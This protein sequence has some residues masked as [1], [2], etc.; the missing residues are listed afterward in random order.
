MGRFLRVPVPRAEPEP[1]L[2]L[3]FHLRSWP[4][5]PLAQ[6]AMLA[7]AA[8]GTSWT[9]DPSLPDGSPPVLTL[10]WPDGRTKV[11]RDPLG[12]FELVEAC[13]PDYPLLPPDPDTQDLAW[14]LV[15]LAALAQASLSA[16]TRATES[17]DH[18]MAVY[19]LR[20]RLL[21]LEARLT[22]EP[23]ES[24]FGL[25]DAALGPMLW[26]LRVL[27]ETCETF[28]LA[29]LPRLEAREGWLAGHPAMRAVFGPE[30][31]ATYLATLA[32][33]GAVVLSV[34]DAAAWRVLLGHSGLRGAG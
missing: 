5:C 25:V 7:L 32:R 28:L 33:R 9:H 18:D 24:T 11:E 29:G 2:A 31:V 6:R 23:V 34:T 21:K 3:G 26:R 22:E 12:I 17:N 27:D 16:V 10:A 4:F 13:H 30:A 8:R 19:R 20:A 14:D 15:H 1:S